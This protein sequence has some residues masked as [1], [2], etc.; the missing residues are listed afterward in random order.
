[1]DPNNNS[2]KKNTKH[3]AGRA[4]PVL[5]WVGRTEIL[6]SDPSRGRYSSLSHSVRKNFGSHPTSYLIGNEVP[7]G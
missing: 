5:L 1:M 4:Q 2:K 7:I 3:E 6:D